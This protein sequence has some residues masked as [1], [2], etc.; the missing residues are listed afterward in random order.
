MPFLYKKLITCHST[1]TQL[2]L[3]INSKGGYNITKD[4]LWGKSLNALLLIIV[5][6][7][8]VSNVYCIWQ[9]TDLKKS[10][11]HFFDKTDPKSVERLLKDYSTQ[12]SDALTKLDELATFTAKLHQGHS[13]ALSK[14]GMI[15]FNPFND[16]G[17]DQSFCLA[18]LD[19]HD[20]G[21]IISSIHART[22]TRVYAKEISG[23]KSKHNLSDEESI[24][25]KRALTV[26]PPT[27][28]KS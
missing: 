15:R 1:A 3:P 27:V 10:Y 19:S 20:N 16:T 2:K 28:R 13:I 21:F 18:A 14:V 23:G 6:L 26:K 22:G 11:G 5:L 8:V 7:L 4:Y 17:G 9:I 24:A 12:V 25:L